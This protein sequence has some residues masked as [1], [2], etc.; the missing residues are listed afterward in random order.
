VTTLGSSTNLYQ[1]DLDPNQ[2]AAVEHR[3][4]H[5]LIAAGAGSGKT[6]A[7]TY[8]AIS[9]LGEVQPQSLEEYIF[10]AWGMFATVIS[11]AAI[12]LTMLTLISRQSY[13]TRKE[14]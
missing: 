14:M 8:R 9:L 2:R 12:A 6:R 4:S 11:Y 10:Q 13:E 1:G 3:G 5:L 7:L